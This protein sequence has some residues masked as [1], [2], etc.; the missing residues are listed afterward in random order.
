MTVVAAQ[1]LLPNLFVLGGSVDQESGGS[2]VA[3]LEA[4]L[5]IIVPEKSAKVAAFRSKYPEWWLVLTDHIAPGLNESERDV[6]RAR[7]SLAHD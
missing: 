2:I 6:L 3:E 4:S 1:S 7:F 5:R